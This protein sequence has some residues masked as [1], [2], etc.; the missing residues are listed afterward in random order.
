M[1]RTVEEVIEVLEL[2]S[3]GHSGRAI[4]RR[5]GIPQR[6][7][8]H[9][10]HGRIPRPQASVESPAISTDVEPS[11]AYVLGLY[12][13]DGH[14]VHEHRGVYRLT[15]ALARYPGIIQSAAE[16]IQTVAPRTKVKIERVRNGA[17][18]VRCHSKRWHSVSTAW[19]RKKTRAA[20]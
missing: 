6:T 20:D 1:T 8:S 7:V 12:L 11:Y 18:R 10:L 19:P 9:W 5:T 13:G 17:V 14:L 16:A 2:A 15:L 4:S 3:A